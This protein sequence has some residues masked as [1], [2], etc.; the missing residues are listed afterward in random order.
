M[1]LVACS[2]A[3]A[4]TAPSFRAETMEGKKVVLKEYLKPGRV[5]F[6]SFWASWCTPC[7]EELR[8]VTAR[9]GKEPNLP[10]DVLTVNV[11]AAETA[12][13]VKPAIKL[14]KLTFPV[15]LDPNHEIFGKYQDSQTLPYSVLISPKGEIEAVFNGYHEEMFTKVKDVIGK[16]V[17]GGK[18]AKEEDAKKT[19]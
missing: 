12:S 5:L 13:D 14:N 9:L 4:K 3:Q 16:T 2:F 6:L 18:A 11:D 15:I 19:K 10:L 7:L 17:T 1:I 8:L